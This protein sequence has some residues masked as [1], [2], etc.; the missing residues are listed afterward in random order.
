MDDNQYFMDDFGYDPTQ[1]KRGSIP[2]V[3]TGMYMGSTVQNR[4]VANNNNL[5]PSLNKFI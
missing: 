5:K 1:K 4:L 3:S 2:S